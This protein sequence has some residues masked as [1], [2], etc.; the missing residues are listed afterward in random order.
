MCLRVRARFGVGISWIVRSRKICLIVGFLCCRQHFVWL[1][2][3]DLI[4]RATKWKGLG[5]RW[6]SRSRMGDFFCSVCGLGSIGSGLLFHLLWR[7]VVMDCKFDGGNDYGWFWM[8]LWMWFVGCEY[9]AG[10]WISFV[11]RHWV[12]VFVSMCGG[13]LF[14]I[15]LFVLGF[16][17]I[18]K[19]SDVVWVWFPFCSVL[20]IF[21]VVGH[22]REWLCDFEFWWNGSWLFGCFPLFVWGVFFLEFCIVCGICCFMKFDIEWLKWCGDCG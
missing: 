10:K 4:F 8:I 7:N 19:W 20:W 17:L 2:A 13:D 22:F 12:F 3:L 1:R 16:F 5:G 6:C 14:S 15:F 9:L 18:I 11:L 21:W